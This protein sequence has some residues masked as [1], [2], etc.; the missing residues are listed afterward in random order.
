MMA[1][2]S[3][4]DNE[5]YD[6]VPPEEQPPAR[7]A[8]P[9]ALGHPNDPDLPPPPRR[10]HKYTTA[11]LQP[12]RPWKRWFLICL[13]FLVIIAIMVLLSVFLA[14]LFNPPEDEDWTDDNVGNN[15]GAEGGELNGVPDLLPKTGEF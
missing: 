13:A 8:R 5:E 10:E 14:K 3:K 7:K 2:E 4:D 11:N 15:T 6:D 12:E 1:A 9:P